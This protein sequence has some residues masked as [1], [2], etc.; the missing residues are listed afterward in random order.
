M[1]NGPFS[2]D[3]RSAGTEDG[4]TDELMSSPSSLPRQS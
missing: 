1:T 3:L 4:A 2:D